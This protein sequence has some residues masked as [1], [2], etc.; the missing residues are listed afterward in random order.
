MQVE[1]FANGRCLAVSC[2][3]EKQFTACF[4]LKNSERVKLGVSF[5]RTISVPGEWGI[6][7]NQN[8]PRGIPGQANLP[9]DFKTKTKN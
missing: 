5:P 9:K 8:F 6:P 4:D 7:E 2:H 1:D 3:P